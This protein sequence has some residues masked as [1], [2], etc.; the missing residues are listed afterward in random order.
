LIV[1]NCVLNLSSDKEALLRHPFRVLKEGGKFDFSD[2]Y[3]D[4]RIPPHFEEDLIRYG[5]FF[6]NVLFWSDTILLACKVGFEASR[7]FETSSIELKS[8]KL[9]ERVEEIEL[10]SITFRIFELA[11]LELTRQDCGQRIISKG[12]VEDNSH[13]LIFDDSNIVAESEQVAVC[14]NTYRML[15]VSRYVE[16]F[17]FIS[18]SEMPLGDFAANDAATPIASAARSRSKKRGCCQ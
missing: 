4:R 9:G 1:S 8:G 10:Y 16:D 7:V 18:G 11:G 6:S 12:S 14:E 5:E 17:D 13:H 2:V 3:A 15:K